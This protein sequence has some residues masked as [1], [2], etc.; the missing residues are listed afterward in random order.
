MGKIKKC[1]TKILYHYKEEIEVIHSPQDSI[2][3]KLANYNVKCLEPFK[4]SYPDK[5]DD[6]I[7]CGT[8]FQKLPLII[9]ADGASEYVDKD[10]NEIIGEGGGQAA[11][12]VLDTTKEYLKKTLTQELTL[13]DVLEHMWQVYRVCATELKERNI[14]STTT[15]LIACLYEIAISNNHWSTFWCYA[16]EGDGSIVLMN[17]KRK[18]DGKILRTELLRPG[19][20]IDTTAIV[21]YKGTTIPPIVGCIAYEPGDIIYVASDG[22]DIVEKALLKNDKIFLA[23]YIY[24]NLCKNQNAFLLNSS[25]K[26]FRFNDDAVLGIIWTSE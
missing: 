9:V 16:F 6:R 5:D 24:D 22:M 7:F 18:I 21:S 19:Q 3:R 20:K 12:V 25:L 8:I 10:S 17:P 2:I 23:N 13:Q 11:D 15:L 1:L 26:D 14:S 4:Y